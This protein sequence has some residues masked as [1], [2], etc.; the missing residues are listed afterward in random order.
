MNDSL[1]LKLAVNLLTRRGEDRT[2]RLYGPPLPL[3]PLPVGEALQQHAHAALHHAEAAMSPH[4]AQYPLSA[5][6]PPLHHGAQPPQPHA[7]PAEAVHAA[8]TTSCANG[9]NGMPLADTQSLPHS[10]C[11]QP[12]PAAPTSPHPIHHGAPPH[13][14]N[15]QLYAGRYRPSQPGLASSY[16]FTHDPSYQHEELH[17]GHHRE[18][19]ASLAASPPVYS[20]PFQPGVHP[21]SPQQSAPMAEARVGYHDGTASAPQTP[22]YPPVQQQPWPEQVASDGP[23]HGAQQPVQRWS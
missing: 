13:N 14:E 1:P 21:V 22:P 16:P 10:L 7:A 6:S 23:R 20:T 3:G 19:P 2:P 11:Y 5:P 8:S 12:S 15:P 9:D 17:D 18:L 4:P